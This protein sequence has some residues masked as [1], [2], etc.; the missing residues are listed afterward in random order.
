MGLTAKQ[1]QH[2]L[3]GK[4]ARRLHRVT[5]RRRGG[6]VATGGP[7]RRHWERRRNGTANSAPQLR[8][9]PVKAN[10]DELLTWRGSGRPWRGIVGV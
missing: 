5:T 10:E 6:S 8:N 7:A 3:E 2:R 1:R 4:R 9:R